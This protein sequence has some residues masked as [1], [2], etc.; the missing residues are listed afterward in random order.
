MIKFKHKSLSEK[1]IGVYLRE[2][3]FLLLC[4]VILVSGAAGCGDYHEWPPYWTSDLTVHNETSFSIDE[5]YLT[6][7]SESTWGPNQLDDPIPSGSSFTIT[8]ISA[9]TYDVRAVITRPESTYYA[10]IFDVEIE[11]LWIY[12][13]DLYNSDFSGSLE[14]VN[15]TSS[16]IEE[17]Y[18][19]LTGSVNWGR[20]RISSSIEPGGYVHLID[21]PADSYD[22]RIVWEDDTYDYS[23]DIFSLTLTTLEDL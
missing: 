11:P 10:Y 23:A 7:A 5:L 21:F 16:N 2:K 18:V 20:N 12:D 6:P 4:A 13:L 1:I 9:D 14:I 3:V 17:I 8:W 19:K 15:D 22:V